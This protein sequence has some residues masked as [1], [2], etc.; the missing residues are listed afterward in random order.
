MLWKNYWKLK[1]WQYKAWRCNE[2][3]MKSWQEEYIVL[4]PNFVLVFSF[5][6]EIRSYSDDIRFM[7]LCEVVFD[8]RIIFLFTLH[9]SLMRFTNQGN[10]IFSEPNPVRFEYRRREGL[11]NGHWQKYML[12]NVNNNY[13]E[14]HAI[15]WYILYTLAFV[16]FVLTFFLVQFLEHGRNEFDTYDAGST[17]SLFSLSMGHKYSFTFSPFYIFAF[18]VLSFAS[19]VPLYMCWCG[20]V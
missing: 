16:S 7:G 12:L 15:N 2:E 13:K 9:K 1:I 17:Y 6:F 8:P 4:K 19:C 3:K 11:T 5:G 18:N 14:P 10:E 20:M